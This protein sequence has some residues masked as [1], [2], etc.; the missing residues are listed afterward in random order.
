ME[1]IKLNAIK[2]SQPGEAYHFSDN[3]FQAS[4]IGKTRI[5]NVILIANNYKSIVEIKKTSD[6]EEIKRILNI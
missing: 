2:V 4:G 1:R 6:Q 3:Y 5:R